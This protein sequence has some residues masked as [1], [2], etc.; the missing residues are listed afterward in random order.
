MI[1]THNP[2][3]ARI[4]RFTMVRKI[5]EALF[6]ENLLNPIN[7]ANTLGNLYYLNDAKVL[8]FMITVKMAIIWVRGPSQNVQFLHVHDLYHTYAPDSN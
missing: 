2:S 7:K 6:T 3:Y 8:S 4:I 1:N 5:S